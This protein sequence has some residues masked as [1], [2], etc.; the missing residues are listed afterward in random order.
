MPDQHTSCSCGYNR[1]GLANDERCPECGQIQISPP[2]IARMRNAW[3]DS[4][5]ITALISLTF[6]FITLALSG[7]LSV[8]ILVMVGMV[9]NQSGGFGAPIGLILP[10][11]AYLFIVLPAAGITA[12]IAII[13][14]K[15]KHWPLAACSLVLVAVSTIT[16]VIVFGV[17]LLFI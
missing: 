15:G 3:R 5:S 9:A 8:G 1:F 17:G 12:L 4:P 10:V 14:T 16:P 7:T 2:P 11:Y 13:P 6:S